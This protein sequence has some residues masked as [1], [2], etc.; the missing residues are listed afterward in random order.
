MGPA[1]I[2][3]LKLLGTHGGKIGQAAQGLA[4]FNGY[5]EGTKALAGDAIGVLKKL[6]DKWVEMQDIAFQT[7]RSMAMSREMAMRYNRQLMQST[8]ELARQYGITAKEIADF[9]KTYAESVGR[10]IMLTKEQT[11]AMA[12]MSK[13]AGENAGTIIDEFDKVGVGIQRAT[14]YT[15]RLQERAK[16][17]GIS[18]AKATKMM[19][20]N[21]KLAASYSFRNGVAD[22]EK[23]SL[24][25]ASMR[26]DMNAI[27]NATEKFS[28]IEGAIGTSANIQMLGGSFAREFSNPMGAM[29]EAQAD[30]EA[31][32]KRILRTIEGKGIYDAKT[33][34]VKFDPVTMRM[35]KELAK[36]LGMSVDQITN[37]AMASV[38]NEKVN[39]EL[40]ATG[41]W[42]KFSEIEREAIRN[43]SRTN[44]NEETGEHQVTYTDVNGE[45]VTRAIKDLTS[46]ELQIAQDRQMSEDGLFSDV[47]DIKD[48]LE[49]TLGRARGT[50]ST[51]ENITGLGAELDSFIAQFQN[52][53]MGTISGLL[54]GSS[55]QP[56]D[57]FKT[58]SWPTGQMDIGT[59]ANEGISWTDFLSPFMGGTG[60]YAFAEGG[61]VKPIP[62]AALG[63]VIQ[64]S[65]TMG[66]KTPVLANAG[67]MILNPR[68]QKGLF[69]L[70]KDIA[71][72]GLMAYG[73][74][75]LGKKI[76]M[77]GIGTNMALSNVFSGGNLGIG[78]MLGQGVAT[79]ISGRIMRSMSP[80]GMMPM[81]G[82]NRP[83]T[84]MNPTVVMNGQTIMN[85]SI[86]D[87]SLVEQLED[88]ADAAAG[89][90]KATRSFSSKIGQLARKNTLLGG[91][92]RMY[93]RA[94]TKRRALGRKLSRSKIAHKT[95]NTLLNL[96]ESRHYYGGKIADSKLGKGWKN[97]LADSK[98]LFGRSQIA[99]AVG[100]EASQTATVANG[101]SKTANAVGKGGKLLSGVG[102]AG[103]LLGRAGGAV[104][105][106]LTIGS[107]IGEISSASSQYDAKIAE[108]DKAN[109]SELDKARAKDKASKEKNASIGGSVGG[110]GG[111]LAGAAAGAAIGSV[112]PGI[113][114][115]I[116]GAIGG[117]VGGF[118][119]DMLGKGIGGLFG[120]GEEDKFK[121][122]QEERLSKYKEEHKDSIKSN[123]DAV[124]ILTSIDNKL[125]VISG[126]SIGI[127]G[128]ALA[129]PSL[130]NINIKKGIGTVA[131][132]ALGSAFGPLGVL[133]GGML[134]SHISSKV[135]ALPIS[136][137]FMKVE[138]TKGSD[139]ASNPPSTVG[140]T[141]INLNVSGTIKLEGGGKSVDFD[142]SKLIDTPE[143]KRQL[144]DIVTR[145]INENSNS[146]KRNMESERNNMSSQYNKS[147]K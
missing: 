51:K 57:L 1:A 68:E 109:M 118:G 82:F 89:A 8:K 37:P 83:I 135:D 21:I 110:L 4:K 120:G 60:P 39:E 86:G 27:M 73:G 69:D 12:A 62:H 99:N 117:I 93:L 100:K 72:T 74:N 13:L 46:E 91:A 20:D 23:M 108:I 87:G 30:P 95:R 31:F 48:I 146:G 97:L 116:G 10:N 2:Q 141:S 45:L 103:K 130:A 80:M 71:T 75:K 90:T 139:T 43:L 47:Q 3:F 125:S 5:F 105:S 70:L 44:V 52:G 19:A 78:G 33:G 101:V 77:H 41:Q 16:A 132:A 14:A 61:L 15:G 58:A 85:G 119:G 144:A 25:A 65:S 79:T 147:G 32:Q 112:I 11:A 128:K 7:G 28:D 17:L 38:Q 59:H 129:S 22:I 18:P 145:R 137:N 88:V 142:I 143:F 123:D 35:M 136:G 36:N 42:D 104:G 63:T 92:S 76:G 131:G 114:T 54:N 34:A 98:S 138:P 66:D 127:K 122:E 40:R 107:T 50:T 113:G 55:F 6:G 126:K 140:S 134:G 49:R 94:R 124:K 9:Q 121:K 102:K 84:L 26:M 56:W 67:E 106:L 115:L 24:K 64:G 29:F 96:N 111:G 133:A 53:L 81:R